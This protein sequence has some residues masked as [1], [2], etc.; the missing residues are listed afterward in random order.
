MLTAKKIRNR[1][2]AARKAVAP[3][4]RVAWSQSICKRMVGLKQFQSADRVAGFLAFDGEA[5]PRAA[6]VAAIDQGKQVYV[7]TIIAKGTPL[8]FVQWTQDCEMQKNRFN[9]EEPVAPK[10][11]WIE[12]HEL[13]FVIT[14]LVAFDESCNRIGVGGGFYDR[15]FAFLNSNKNSKFSSSKES[16]SK[17]T[18]VQSNESEPVIAQNSSSTLIGFAFELQK[19]ACITTND[20]DVGLHGVVTETTSY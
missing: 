18:N 3:S 17:L 11:T 7:P 1:I 2:R 10:S 12:G 20:W 14:P 8:K 15:T 9:I 16:N 19:V 13:D 5:D 6:M 4:D